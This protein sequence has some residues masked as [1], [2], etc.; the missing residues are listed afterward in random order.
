MG[1]VA[2]TATIADRLTRLEAKVDYLISMME[3]LFANPSVR[4]AI[5]GAVTSYG[6]RVRQ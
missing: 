5:A 1:V 3:P 6:M 4:Q 2:E